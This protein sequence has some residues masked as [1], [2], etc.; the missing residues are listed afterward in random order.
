MANNRKRKDRSEKYSRSN[1]GTPQPEG[2]SKVELHLQATYEF[3]YKAVTEP[4]I[5]HLGA[6]VRIAFYLSILAGSIW[7]LF[8]K[9]RVRLDGERIDFNDIGLDA[10]IIDSDGEGNKGKSGDT[11]E[12]TAATTE[13]QDETEA[14]EYRHMSLKREYMS[15]GPFG[16]AQDEEHFTKDGLAK[17]LSIMYK[18]VWIKFNIV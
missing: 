11:K 15:K 5:T 18:H 6:Y 1:Y 13:A 17:V 10:K 2:P 8:F 3:Y 4:G 14:T 7:Y 16:M 12:T 9:D